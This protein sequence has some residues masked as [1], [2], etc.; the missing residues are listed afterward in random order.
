MIFVGLDDTDIIGSRGTNQ[1]A[2]QLAFLLRP[3]FRCLR[4]VRHQL[5]LDERVPYTS[6]NGSASIWLEP[7]QSHDIGELIESLRT[8]MR[9]AFIIGSDPGL[10]VT[11]D[12]VSSNIVKFGRRCQA[13][14]VRAADAEQLAG[15]CGLYLEGLGGTCGGVIGALAAVGLAATANDGR[16]VQ[17]DAMDGELSGGQ[18]MSE[19][20]RRDVAV[21]V[22]STDTIITAGTVD[23]G[24][25]MRPNLREGR[26]VLFVSP[27]EKLGRDSHWV[28]QK[29]T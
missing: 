17:W 9:R 25:K 20:M 24:K 23:V 4:I 11:T 28:A 8:E 5:L 7:D 29:L 3:R 27:P 6:K 21:C 18:P 10:C 26:L 16:V 14:V 2:K 1:L 15:E 12:E 13:E 22:D 19:I